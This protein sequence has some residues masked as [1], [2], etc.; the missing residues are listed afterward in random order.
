MRSLSH[1][2]RARAPQL[3]RFNESVCVSKNFKLP[4]AAFVFTVIG[5]KLQLVA[6]VIIFGEHG[7]AAFLGISIES[8]HRE[9]E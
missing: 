5:T 6:C 7:R 1:G 2:R 9:I 8:M 4:P 3:P